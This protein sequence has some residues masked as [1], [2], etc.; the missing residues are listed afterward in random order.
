M[1]TASAIMPP[2]GLSSP[3]R[4]GKAPRRPKRDHAVINNEY[5]LYQNEG[6]ICFRSIRTHECMRFVLQRRIQPIFD[7]DF[8]SDTIAVLNSDGLLVVFRYRDDGKKLLFGP[9]V[10]QQ[11]A[12]DQIYLC[13]AP[14]SH[15]LYGSRDAEYFARFDDATNLANLSEK[16]TIS[17]GNAASDAD[18]RMIFTVSELGLGHNVVSLFANA[19]VAADPASLLSILVA[20]EVPRV[21]IYL[22]SIGSIL[23]ITSRRIRVTNCASREETAEP[24]TE[25]AS[26]TGVLLRDVPGCGHAVCVADSGIFTIRYDDSGRIAVR[27]VGDIVSKGKAPVDV[28]VEAETEL[29]G[30]RVRIVYDGND[31]ECSEHKIDLPQPVRKEAP[32][33]PHSGEEEEFWTGVEKHYEKLIDSWAE[34]TEKKVSEDLSSKL[35]ERVAE[36]AG[37]GVEGH[38]KRIEEDIAQSIQGYVDKCVNPERLQAQLNVINEN[39]QEN[40]AMTLQRTFIPSFEESCNKMFKDLAKTYREGYSTLRQK[41]EADDSVF[42]GNV[43]DAAAKRSA[44]IADQMQTVAEQQTETAE[45]TEEF[46]RTKTED[47]LARLSIPIPAAAPKDHSQ[48]PAPHPRQIDELFA[49]SA[50]PRAG[51][52]SHQ[53]PDRSP[54]QAAVEQFV[55]ALRSGNP[56][57]ALEVAAEKNLNQKA[58]IDLLD[59]F[60]ERTIQESMMRS[61]QIPHKYVRDSLRVILDFL[62]GNPT[63]IDAKYVERINKAKHLLVPVKEGYE[64]YVE[65]YGKFVAFARLVSSQRK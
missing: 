46:V 15:V 60:D 23:S 65:V 13:K 25:F 19:Q 27:R 3:E 32:T 43:Y 30:L 40:M 1:D 49:E 37:A 5:V 54:R 11:T 29:E 6:D 51:T 59:S 18:S 33:E 58:M 53:L 26:S 35:E 28:K 42:R 50:T 61:P 34:D 38:M 41:L 48:S 47:L 21:L 39:L 14:D 62:L 10:Y 56:A 20:D 17:P 9:A 57:Q 55:S 45:R 63:A 44:I 16:L 12:L 31:D 22:A 8:N 4:V 36:I 24:C 2:P 7:I 52:G 64:D